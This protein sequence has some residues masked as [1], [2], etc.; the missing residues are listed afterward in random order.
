MGAIYVRRRWFSRQSFLAGIAN[1]DGLLEGVHAPD[2]TGA[3][4][5]IE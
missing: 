4:V 3:S 1:D 5:P 2:A